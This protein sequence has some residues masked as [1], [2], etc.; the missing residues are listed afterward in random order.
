MGMLPSGISFLVSASLVCYNTYYSHKVDPSGAVTVVDFSKA[1]T[2]EDFGYIGLPRCTSADMDRELRVV[3]Y[4]LDFEGAKQRERTAARVS[5]P[6]PTA[7]PRDTDKVWL[8]RARHENHL[9]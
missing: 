2:L 1:R 5:N 6:L 3:K 8:S 7:Q 9:R 4:M